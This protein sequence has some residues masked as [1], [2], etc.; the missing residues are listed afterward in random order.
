MRSVKTESSEQIRLV[1][2]IR[3]FYP[4]VIVFSVP[5]GGGRSYMEATKLREEGV[6]AGVCDLVVLEARGGWFGLFIEMKRT[7]GGKVSE[8]QT[9]FMGRARERG[10]KCVV[11]HGCEE[12]WAAFEKYMARDET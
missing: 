7:S 11:A 9:Q 12:G 3:H 6:L 2:R 8:E 1:G 5:N 10:Y 4:D